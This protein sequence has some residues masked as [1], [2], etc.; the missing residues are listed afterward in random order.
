[1]TTDPTKD[2]LIDPSLS[3]LPAHLQAAVQAGVETG[4]EGM[5]QY[6]TPPRLKVCQSNRK[7]QYKVFPEKT[8]LV[9]P[10]NDVICPPDGFFIFTPIY[11]F[12]MFC[13]HNPWALRETLNM[14]RESSHDP[15]SEI[16]RKCR[17]FTTEPCPEDPKEEIKYATHINT[18]IYIHGVEA[19]R[20]TPVILSQF[21]G[22]W[23]AGRQ[24]MNLLNARTANGTPIYAHKLMG[25]VNLRKKKGN[26][27]YGVDVTNPSADYDGTPWVE[28]AKLFDEFAKLREQ[29]KANREKIKVDFSDE[30][31]GSNGGADTVT[32]DTL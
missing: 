12:D 23:T 1:M 10:Q 17:T 22:E 32:K 16:G 31:A 8:V 11:T 28:D 19:L 25:R 26:E 29:T 27:W 18:L 13:V 21:L 2:Q 24:M 6:L 3:H 9:V 5:Q 4:M 7:E 30:D 20:H 14:I 15:D